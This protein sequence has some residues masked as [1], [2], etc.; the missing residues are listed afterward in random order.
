[1]TEDK[2]EIKRTRIIEAAFQ[3]FSTKNY[4]EVMIDDVAKIASIAKGT[5][6]NYFSSKEELYFSI[7]R[8]RMEKLL[9]SLKKIIESETSIINSLHAYVIHLYMFMMK[10]QSFFLIYRK[11]TLKSENDICAEILFM[12][13]E[14]RSLLQ[15]LIGQGNKEGYFRSFEGQYAV[16]LT[17]GA[18]TGAISR[19]IERNLNEEQAALERENLFDFILQ[20]LLSVSGSEMLP[21]RGKTILITRSVD[22]SKESADH[23]RKLGADVIT[24]PTLEIVPPDSWDAFDNIADKRN[25]IDFL[26]FT[27]AHSVKMFRKRIDDLKLDF[28]FGKV[29]VVAIGNKTA[30]VCESNN[31]PVHIIPSRFSSEGV[32]EE[33]CTVGM[34]GKKVFIPRSAIGRE[35]L[36][37]GLERLGAVILS[38][39]VYNIAIP[40]AAAIRDYILKL[41]TSKVDLYVF[42]SPSTFENFLKILNIGEPGNYF[43]GLNIA[44]IGPTTR[45][46]IESF[47]VPVK[48]MPEEFNIEGL[49]RAVIK[50]Y[51]TNGERST[52]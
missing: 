24:F 27:S 10:Y 11:E 47:K 16:D 9:S 39:P 31:I 33:L 17:L 48:V 7:M 30:A 49:A 8:L 4:H 45:T 28:N 2:K 23:F 3:L 25:D 29:K 52:N 38:A 46:A 41:N 14:L 6:Y 21:L 1:M 42:T 13:T 22:Q 15:N 50:F 34:E 26:I 12:E 5:V 43:K 37:A 51:K 35:E 36:P 19:G 18:I 32:I 40:D 44:A 20:G